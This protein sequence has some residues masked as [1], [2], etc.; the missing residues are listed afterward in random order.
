MLGFVVDPRL[1]APADDEDHRNGI[2]FIVQQRRNRVD[3]IAFSAVLHVHYRDFAG[4]EVIAGGQCCTVAFVR[5]DHVMLR[6][7]PV[8]VHQVIAEGFQLGIRYPGI[9]IC[10]QDFCKI[11][12]FHVSIPFLHFIL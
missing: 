10:I 11:F 3:D 2:D 7:D 6:I 12:Y 5:R 4:G 9:K 8:G 1:A